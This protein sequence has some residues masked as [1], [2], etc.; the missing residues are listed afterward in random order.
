M[1]RPNDTTECGD[2]LGTSFPEGTAHS[3]C[4]GERHFGLLAYPPQYFECTLAEGDCDV[5]QKERFAPLVDE[6]GEYM[7]QLPQTTPSPPEG[8][9][10]SQSPM[11]VHICLGHGCNLRC[12]YCYR[13]MSPKK[14]LRADMSEDMARRAIDFAFTWPGFE[15]RLLGFNFSQT[16]EPLLYLEAINSARGY[17]IRKAAECGRPAVPGRMLNTNGTL[18]TREV[19]SDPSFADYRVLLSIDGPPAVHDQNRKYADG[20][21]SYANVTTALTRLLDHGLVENVSAVFT[22]VNPRILD[23]F[24]HLVGLGIGEIV[25]K[26]ARLAP[27]HPLAITHT[28]V[29]NV[30]GEYDRFVEYLMNLPDDEFIDCL[31]R[32]GVSD[33]FYRFVRRVVKRV[34]VGYRC[35][36][37]AERICIDTDGTIYPC[38]SFTG[39]PDWSLGDIE[40]GIDER[41]VREFFREA[42]VDN[43][44]SCRG[45][46]ARYLCGGGCYYHSVMTSGSMY[47]PDD[48]KCRLVKHIIELAV[49]FADHLASRDQEVLAVL[50]YLDVVPEEVTPNCAIGYSDVS[51]YT[52]KPPCEAG[53]ISLTERGLTRNKS[54]HGKDDLS[55]SIYIWWNDECLC[56]QAD[57]TDDVF[58][59]PFSASWFYAGDCLRIGVHN[60]KADRTHEFGVALMGAGPMAFRTTGGY[61]ARPLE[62]VQVGGRRSGRRTR[63][64]AAIPWTELDGV[65]EPNE[66][67][68]FSVA[69]VDNDRTNRGWIQWTPGLIPEV[70]SDQFGGLT[71]LR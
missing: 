11:N 43:R 37:V 18:I 63:Y 4:F 6:L 58:F 13:P 53:L 49:V 70:N 60:P 56:I 69:V 12:E 10:G 1:S 30:M 32:L 17:I 28:N 23:T 15:G 45:C 57:V 61:S 35:P 20:R 64:A 34:S 2:I 3:F 46:W 31:V 41:K 47:V 24:L 8:V 39:M 51:V 55:A 65:P 50:G 54:W 38:G 52:E 68:P 44:E 71:F 33:F 14:A 9:P 66:S 22:G 36:A 40:N 16:C 59:Q 27:E 7:S 62:S 26:P 42:Y 5:G 29:G 48:A 25:I 67:W 21:G 19:L